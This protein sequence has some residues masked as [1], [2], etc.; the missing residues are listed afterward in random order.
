MS[1]EVSAVQRLFN[2]CRKK[3]PDLNHIDECIY[4]CHCNNED[5]NTLLRCG[6]AK[7][8]PLQMA[9]CLGHYEIVERLLDSNNHF[10]DSVDINTINKQFYYRT[11]LHFACEEK[12]PL[13]VRAL[14]Q[15]PNVEVNK[16]DD[17][18]FTPLHI[19]CRNKKS[20]A[21]AIVMEL[22]NHP[23]I[24]FIAKDI[25]G[26]IPLHHA[27]CSNKM[28]D[29]D[30]IQMLLCHQQQKYQIVQLNATTDY[31]HIT[32]LHVAC[33]RNN[34]AAVVKLL[35][36]N[37]N[38]INI[39]ATDRLGNTPLH[40]A[41]TDCHI[42]NSRTVNIIKTLLE[43]PFI[44]IHKKNKNGETPYDI[45]KRRLKF[46]RFL[47]MKPCVIE[48]LQLLVDFQMR[49]RWQIY[50]FLINNNYYEDSAFNRQR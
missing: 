23:D 10:K 35:E 33:S 27:C 46:L 2:E 4:E 17:L 22:L 43:H 6:S 49:Q 44:M 47:D 11:A 28:E 40:T 32:P 45:S 38:I 14:L 20:N 24:Q 16:V 48:I 8:T 13:T 41:C 9:C 39:N 19:A 12:C 1:N 3:Y 21:K 30:I 36:H 18:Q 29:T 5:I 34:C 31:E 26:H 15:H 37:T 50:C 25:D 42:A 7:L